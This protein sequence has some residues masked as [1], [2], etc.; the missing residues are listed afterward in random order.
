MGGNVSEWMRETYED[1][2]P[3]FERNQKRL[4]EVGS[5][6]AKLAHDVYSYYDDFCDKDGQLV[7]GCNWYDVRHA[8]IYGKNK[9]GMNAKTFVAPEKSFPTLG[10]RYVVYVE[11]R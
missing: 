7:R 9:A 8:D 3:A 4:L 11:E 1:W 10:F 2:Q 5:A 6:D